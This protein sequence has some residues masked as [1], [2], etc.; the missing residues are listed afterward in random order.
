MD[1]E[2]IKRATPGGKGADFR[3]EHTPDFV[4]LSPLSLIA[5]DW[6][7][8]NTDDEASWIGKALAVEPRRIW[9]L[10]EAIVNDGM[11]FETGARI[12]PYNV[13]PLG[14]LNPSVPD[15]AADISFG[16]AMIPEIKKII[17]EHELREQIFARGRAADAAWLLLLRLYLAEIDG[18]TA[19]PI[20]AD[21]QLPPKMLAEAGLIEWRGGYAR[22]CAN[23][24]LTD[25]GRQRLA[26]YL[27]RLSPI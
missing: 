20:Q 4:L 23:V 6:L 12:D 27:R 3:V 13:A 2:S 25:A 15:P 5:E 21:S 8:Q 22:D 11:I 16:Q 18:G 9:A 19:K 7:G 1:P 24:K 26:R 17:A 10:L 14:S